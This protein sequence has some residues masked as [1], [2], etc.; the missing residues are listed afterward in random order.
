V[1][2]AI[3]PGRSSELAAWVMMLRIIPSVSAL[4]PSSAG[5]GVPLQLSV[6]VSPQEVAG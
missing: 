2:L 6:P 5:K 1:D 4:S 3:P